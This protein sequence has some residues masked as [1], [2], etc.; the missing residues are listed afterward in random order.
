[1]GACV[2]TSQFP[3]AYVRRPASVSA[4]P[5]G[6]ITD[7]MQHME[8]GEG[9]ASPVSASSWISSD[10]RDD[11]SD[12]PGFNRAA[13]S[14]HKKNKKNSCLVS[15]RGRKNSWILSFYR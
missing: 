9:R 1:M 2:E 13:R 15:L 12:K 4:A 7:V 3:S 10:E 8:T 6:D 5:N 14:G 11:Y